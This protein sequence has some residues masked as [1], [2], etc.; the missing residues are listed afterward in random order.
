MICSEGGGWV[1]LELRC[2]AVLTRV[3]RGSNGRCLIK[4]NLRVESRSP[5]E[6]RGAGPYLVIIF[7]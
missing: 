6:G 4:S 2:H 5:G 1:M 3:K 7:F